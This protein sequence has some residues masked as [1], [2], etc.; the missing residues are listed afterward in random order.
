MPN[1]PIQAVSLTSPG[2]FGNNTQDSGV[3]LDQSFSLEGDNAVIDKSGRMASRKG[4]EYNTTA[5]GTSTLPEALVEFDAYTATNSYNII[6]GGNNN[7]Y[8]GEGT[9]SAM[10]VYN[11]AG[12]STITYT[13]T[14]N[15]WQFKQAEFES[16]LNFSPHMYAVQKDHPPLVYHKLPVGGGGG[17]SHAHTGD[18]GLQRLVDVGNV[19]SGYAADTFTPNVA[20]S[21]FGRMFFADIVNDPLT[22]YFSVLLDGSDLSGSGSGQLNLEKVIAGGDKIVALA[23]HNSALIIFCE[24]NIVIYNNADDISNIALADTIIGIGCVA[25]DSIQ[26]IGTDL[27]FL[28][29]SGVR[30]LGR[31]IQEK[32]APLRDLTK[33]VRDN[34][35]SLLAVENKSKIRSVYYQKEAFYLLTMPNS[36]FTFCFDVRALLPDQS[37]RVTR[38][39]SIEP[40]SLLTTKDNRLLLG[41]TNGIAQYK[42][43]TDDGSP[44]VFSYLSPYL[45]FGN[46]S[47]TKILKKINVTVVGAS[48]T[49]LSIKYAFD[50]N[51]N[52]DSIDATTKAASISEFGVAEYNIAEFSASIFIDKIT[53]QL[54]GSGNVLQIGVNASINGNALSLQKLDIYSVLGRTI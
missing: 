23:E 8:E 36:G 3:T 16:G 20:L 33:N 43:F 49:T 29:S 14:D 6:S 54:T 5:G 41:K 30:S 18:F 7:L 11:A 34:F 4:W 48:S 50:Y 27:I 44:Y 51:T 15:N 42:N 52:Y 19:P 26:N 25:R 40:S 46:Q 21:A 13:I 53:A 38:W 10:P 28:S 9:M 22:I 37:Y 45:D 39:D 32:S 24:R 12:N 17:G 1:K 35:L 47:L 2:F 31:T